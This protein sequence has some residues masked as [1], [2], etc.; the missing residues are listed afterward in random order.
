MACDILCRK[1]AKMLFFLIL[2]EFRTKKA[3][4]E[5]TELIFFYI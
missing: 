3:I 1:K 2:S 4:K 5:L